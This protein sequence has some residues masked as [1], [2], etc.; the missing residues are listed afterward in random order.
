[1]VPV[2]TAKS[3]LTCTNCGKTGHLMETCHNRKIKVPI[4]PTA[5]IKFKKL[6]VGTKPK[7]LN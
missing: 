6:V 3:T 5:T 4:V 1:M 7:L 2:V